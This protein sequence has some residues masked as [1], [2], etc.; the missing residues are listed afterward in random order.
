M[1][2]S[3]IVGLLIVCG[4][5]RTLKKRLADSEKQRDNYKEQAVTI[6]Q[7]LNRLKQEQKDHLL[8]EN[9]NLK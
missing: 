9:D 8:E 7:K 2:P 5:V 3:L 4:Q 6:C 1:F